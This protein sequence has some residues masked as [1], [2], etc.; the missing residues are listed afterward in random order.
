M[1]VKEGIRS[2]VWINMTEIYILYLLS[3]VAILQCNWY[4]VGLAFHGHVFN[5]QPS[6]RCIKTL[7]KFLT[8]CF[9][10]HQAV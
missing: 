2:D 5:S 4:G 7:G 10:C 9:L 8:P 3:A 1:V 6:S